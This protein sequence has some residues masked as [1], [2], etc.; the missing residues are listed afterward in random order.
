MKFDLKKPVLLGRWSHIACFEGPNASSVRGSIR[1]MGGYG[2]VQPSAY[3][4]W[5][6]RALLL[7]QTKSIVLHAVRK[8]EK[9][10]RSIGLVCMGVSGALICPSVADM[11]DMRFCVIRQ[12]GSEACDGQRFTHEHDDIVGVLTDDLIFVDE[13]FD[14]GRS[15]DRVMDV[16]DQFGSKLVGIVTAIGHVYDLLED[17]SSV[18]RPNII[19]EISQLPHAFHKNVPR[20]VASE[21][22]ELHEAGMLKM[23]KRG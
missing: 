10:D 21:I 2:P 11:L 7:Q 23:R 9:T 19:D 22:F 1:Y 20:W 8:L 5:D 15:T 16:L 18:T 4:R 13:I 14:K 6:K 3:E 12:P 17:A